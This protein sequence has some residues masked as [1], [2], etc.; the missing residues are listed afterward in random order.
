[1]KSCILFLGLILA[2]CQSAQHSGEMHHHAEP[3]EKLGT[4][5][6]PISCSSEVQKQFGLGVALLHSYW[7]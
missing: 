6:F 7:Y 4:V 5:S 2:L 1:M 3:L